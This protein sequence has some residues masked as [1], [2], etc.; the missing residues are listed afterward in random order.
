MTIKNNYSLSNLSGLENLQSVKFAYL[1]IT[2]N[3]SLADLNMENL[4]KVGGDFTIT[5]NPKLCETDV[6]TLVNRV[7]NCGGVGGNTTISNNKICCEEQIYNGNY[8]IL[9]QSDINGL[10]GYTEVTGQLTIGEAGRNSDIVNLQGLECLKKVGSSLNIWSN[11]NMT[12]LKGL[13]NLETVGGSF[14]LWSNRNLLSLED[15]SGLISVGGWLNINGNHKLINLKGFDNLVSAGSL[16]VTSN[17][18]LVSLQSLNKVKNLTFLQ[19][20]NNNSL[21]SLQGLNNL[22][23]I[24]LSMTIKNNYSLSNL[25]G[26]ENLQSVKFAYLTITG[27]HSL[28]SLNMESLCRVGGEFTI[29]N[30]PMLCETDAKALADQVINCDGIGK[31]VNVSSNK[32]CN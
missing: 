1:T 2:G 6:E 17:G 10:S 3:N 32:I 15:L 11:Q 16:F 24:N 19:I 30:N 28:S 4:C 25:S 5:N 29:T 31:T 9:S 14:S 18:G 26:L 8:T 27:N 21:L 22:L 12:S 20:D 7:N 23:S 13:N